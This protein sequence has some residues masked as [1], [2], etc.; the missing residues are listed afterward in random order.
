MEVWQQGTG[1]DLVCLVHPVGGDIQAYRALVSELAPHLTVCL[2]ADPALRRADLPGW[3]IADRA[4]RYHAALQARFPHDAWQWRL[5]GWSFGAWV[6]H[7]M[8]AQAE[9]AGHPAT[10][11]YLLDPPPPGAA[12]HFQAYDETQFD[13]VFAHELGQGDAGGA[14]S[15]RAAAYAERLARCCRANVAG[16]ARHELP[17]LTGTP[18]RVWLAGRAVAGLPP[19]G[20][21]DAQRRSWQAEL[22]RLASCDVLD[23][24]HYGIVRTPQVRVVATT[25]NADSRPDATP[26]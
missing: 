5:A 26:R 7:A 21:P 17:R 16:L 15:P 20:A 4:R 25:I 22:P 13:A 9:A 6:A 11:L 12:R 1:R 10:R 3:S 18:T 8:A 2:I 19:M 14:A 23:A 24:T